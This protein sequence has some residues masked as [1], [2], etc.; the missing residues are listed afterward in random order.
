MLEH[1][2]AFQ[3]TV[4]H[5]ITP[6]RH[7]ARH[8]LACAAGGKVQQLS[9]ACILVLQSVHA[10]PRSTASAAAPAALFR[11][12]APAAGRAVAA[13][14]VRGVKPCQCA[15]GLFGI[16]RQ[17]CECMGGVQI[18]GNLASACPSLPEFAKCLFRGWSSWRCSASAKGGTLDH[19]ARR[20]QGRTGSSTKASLAC[21]VFARTSFTFSEF[22]DPRISGPLSPLCSEADIAC[23]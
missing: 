11:P 13:L 8:Q 15:K 17:S 18:F 20:S 2:A 12:P 6:E 4:Y 16:S 23:C 9:P 7:I 19:G 22:S 5:V 14:A 1:D 3:E 21:E 10:H